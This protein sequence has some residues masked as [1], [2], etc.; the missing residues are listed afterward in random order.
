MA[1]SGIFTDF[2]IDNSKDA[3]TIKT[4]KQKQE[5]NLGNGKIYLLHN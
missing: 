4:G 3:T 1:T 2:V 5:N